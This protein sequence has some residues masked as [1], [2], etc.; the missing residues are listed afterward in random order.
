MDYNILK[1][2]TLKAMSNDIDQEIKKIYKR[3]KILEEQ[4]ETIDLIIIHR[5]DPNFLD[6]DEIIHPLTSSD[7]TDRIARIKQKIQDH[8]N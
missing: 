4:K 3:V 6:T 1:T 7:I 5:D 8:S 2:F